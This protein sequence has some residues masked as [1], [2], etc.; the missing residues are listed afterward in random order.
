MCTLPYIGAMNGKN[1]KMKD[2]IKE[3]KKEKIN[4]EESRSLY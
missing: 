4:Y 3:A 1:Q 2:K